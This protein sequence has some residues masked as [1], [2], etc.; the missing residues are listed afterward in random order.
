MKFCK[1]FRLN[2]VFTF[3]LFCFLEPSTNRVAACIAYRPMVLQLALLQVK[4]HRC[5]TNLP[6]RRFTRTTA[7]SKR[8]TRQRIQRFRPTTDQNSSWQITNLAVL[9]RRVGSCILVSVHFYYFYCALLQGK[10]P[11]AYTDRHYIRRGSCVIYAFTINVVELQSIWHK[12][13]VLYYRMYA[14]SKQSKNTIS[15][16]IEASVY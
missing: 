6:T 10:L 12:H 7:N 9:S 5:V 2:Y 16:N 3:A 13:N 15:P 1:T 11:F 4:R 14:L 8:E